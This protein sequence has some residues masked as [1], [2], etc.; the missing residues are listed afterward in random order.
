M[1]V[2]DLKP[3]NNQVIIVNFPYYNSMITK[4][5]ANN[6]LLPTEVYLQ[7]K[8]AVVLHAEVNMSMFLMLYILN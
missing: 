4:Q 2:N 6:N 1:P 8:N 3:F 7:G 5:P